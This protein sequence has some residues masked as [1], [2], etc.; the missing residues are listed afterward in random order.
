MKRDEGRREGRRASQVG[1]GDLPRV[2]VTGM[3]RQATGE[4]GR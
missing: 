1:T 2:Q 4:T 3:L